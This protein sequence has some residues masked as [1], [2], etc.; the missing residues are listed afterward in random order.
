MNEKQWRGH[1]MRAKREQSQAGT[2]DKLSGKTV[3]CKLKTRDL[4]AV[5]SEWWE[6][7]KQLQGTTQ[8]DKVPT[9]ET[10]ECSQEEAERTVA[11]QSCVEKGRCH[12][13]ARI[14]GKLLDVPKA[15]VSS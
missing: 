1:D 13:P 2:I 10:V 14:L 8:N 12:L 5:L 11:W 7:S 9:T 6:V 3:E 15:S 4:Q